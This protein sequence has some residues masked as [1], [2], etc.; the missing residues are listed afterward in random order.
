[1]E[2]TPT[3]L[4]QNMPCEAQICPTTRFYVVG[5]GRVADQ[6]ISSIKVMFE[7]VLVIKAPV[8]AYKSLP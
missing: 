1:M 8:G 7:Y 6:G 3:V 4:S 2:N 5:I